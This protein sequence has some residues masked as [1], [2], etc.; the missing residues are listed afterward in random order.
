[1]LDQSLSRTI[2][3]ID[4]KKIRLRYLM[5]LIHNRALNK[6]ITL[7]EVMHMATSPHSDKPTNEDITLATISLKELLA[8]NLIQVDFI[9]KK[10]ENGLRIDVRIIGLEKP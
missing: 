4:R 9:A 10:Y 3:E 7:S 6:D 2:I 5:D 8:R 1:M